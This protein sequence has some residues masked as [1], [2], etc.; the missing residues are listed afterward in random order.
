M[1][2]VTSMYNKNRDSSSGVR[3]CTHFTMTFFILVV[4]TLTVVQV[5]T[6]VPGDP[7][8][9][10]ITAD[11]E[12]DASGEGQQGTSKLV[13]FNYNDLQSDHHNIMLIQ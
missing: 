13:L 12:L 10:K 11:I 2:I 4:L 8:G 9:L 1:N 7:S 6:A 3:T 5:S